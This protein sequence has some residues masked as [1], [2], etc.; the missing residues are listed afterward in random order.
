MNG[1]SG[2]DWDSQ[3]SSPANCQPAAQEEEW[4]V[5]IWIKP[6]VGKGLGGRGFA[7]LCTNHRAP[8][9]W[10]KAPL[11]WEDLGK[12][13]GCPTAR[14]QEEEEEEENQ[15]EPA[16]PGQGRELSRVSGAP[17]EA[18]ETRNQQGPAPQT[19]P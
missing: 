3:S 17:C 7:L 19:V 14:H 15:Q 11:P 4:G 8:T 9:G 2:D 1:K 5:S 18:P 10:V 6:G 12:S 13:S 16:A